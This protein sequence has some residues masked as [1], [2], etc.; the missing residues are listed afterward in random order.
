MVYFS[1]MPDWRNLS[2][3]EASSWIVS[4]PD[5]FTKPL[6]CQRLAATSSLP[7]GIFLSCKEKSQGPLFVGK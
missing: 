4:A 1:M 5:I 2:S 3:D 6:L 7:A